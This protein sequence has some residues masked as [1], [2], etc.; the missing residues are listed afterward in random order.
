[1]CQGLSWGHLLE[2]LLKTRGGLVLVELELLLHGGQP[3][4][5]LLECVL[6]AHVLLELTVQ[7]LVDLPTNNP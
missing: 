4:L 3:G 5:A 1:M 2:G 6:V 7:A